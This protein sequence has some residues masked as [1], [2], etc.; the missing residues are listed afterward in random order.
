MTT[1]L[2]GYAPRQASERAAQRR[3]SEDTT[4]LGYSPSEAAFL[5][6]AA[7]TRRKALLYQPLSE[8]LLSLLWEEHPDAR[9]TLELKHPGASRVEILEQWE[10]QEGRPAD[11]S[12]WLPQS[13]GPGSLSYHARGW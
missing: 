8:G 2:D 9:A 3:A 10:A 13:H 4:P 1:T 6:R 11:T 5:R 12:T 7:E